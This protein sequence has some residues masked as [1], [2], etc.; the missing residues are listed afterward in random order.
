MPAGGFELKEISPEQMKKN[1]K[2][3]KGKKAWIC[4]YS[5]KISAPP[6]SEELRFLTKLFFRSGSIPKFGS[7]QE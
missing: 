3:M 2:G 6:L 5:L 7:L 4:G 1:I